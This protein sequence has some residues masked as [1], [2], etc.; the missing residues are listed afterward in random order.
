MFE[1]APNPVVAAAPSSDASNTPDSTAPNTYGTAVMTDGGSRSA[2]RLPLGR[3]RRW[4][5]PPHDDPR[6]E[7]TIRAFAG[8]GPEAGFASD[9]ETLVS[10]A[11]GFATRRAWQDALRREEERLARYGGPVTIVVTEI[12]GLESLAATP[13]RGAA[14]RLIPPIEA[15]MRQSARAVDILART[16]RW[17]FVALLPETDEVAAINY[18]ERVRSECDAW[19]ETLGPEF[20][21]AMG[22]AQPIGG[23]SLADALLVAD[24]RMAADRRRH[25]FGGPAAAAAL[26]ATA[27][28]PQ[29]SRR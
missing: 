20:R 19:L 3:P 23:A 16:G 5:L 11:T 10:P 28:E 27:E 25:G 6:D 2:P 15:M 12:D 1:S 18:V 26:A 29:P 24:D 13:G 7:S 22:W 17:S 14:D 21:L 9:N 4:R 8:G